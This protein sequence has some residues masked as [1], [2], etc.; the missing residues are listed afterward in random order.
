MGIFNEIVSEMVEKLRKELFLEYEY[1]SPQN[2]P[3]IYSNGLETLNRKKKEPNS[4]TNQFF[5]KKT[6]QFL[7]NNQYS[8]YTNNPTLK[9]NPQTLVPMKDGTYFYTET[10]QLFANIFDCVMALSKD[11]SVEELF[12][13]ISWQE[14]ETFI[15][16]SLNFYGYLSLR[17]FRFNLGKKRH[18]VDII[19][20]DQY[21][22][23]FIDA[24]HWNTKTASPSSLKTAADK[25][26]IRAQNLAK[27]PQA[28]GRLLQK[29]KHSSS[30]K[31][32]THQIYPIILVSSNLARNTIENGVPILSFNKFNEFLNHFYH[33]KPQL[34]SIPL[35][36]VVFQTKLG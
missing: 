31:F 32:K 8:K 6:P 22:L 14:F 28:A 13:S 21:R 33:F 1:S 18:E 16:K 7:R 27:N 19:A 11:H 17:T 29:L 3:I 26:V 25:Q 2:F 12:P 23:L 36:K 9:F 24:K 10:K 5:Y 20:R 30:K 4:A 15:M 35:D 34:K